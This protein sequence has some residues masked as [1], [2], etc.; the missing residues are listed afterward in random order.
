MARSLEDSTPVRPSL[1]AL[2]DYDINSLSL[3]VYHHIC[4]WFLSKPWSIILQTPTIINVCSVVERCPGADFA[5]WR[6]IVT[7]PLVAQDWG[8]WG[9][10]DPLG[11]NKYIRD[12][13]WIR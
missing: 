11:N 10:W 4:F 3:D 12:D 13:G 5:S 8:G 2:L 9:G 7:W 6:T 1:E